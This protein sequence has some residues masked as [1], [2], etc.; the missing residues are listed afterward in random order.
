MA[1]I[2]GGV[3]MLLIAAGWSWAAEV[4]AVPPAALAAAASGK[5]AKG[6]PV[7]AP[8]VSPD[9][10]YLPAGKS[11]PFRPFIDTSMTPQKK[12]EAEA[13]K[14]VVVK[15]RSISPLQQAEIEKF[16]LVGIVGDDERRTAVVEDGT[17]KKFYP[18]FMGTT[19]GMN[20]G[21]IVS[22]LPD[23]VIIEERF[24]D[25]TKKTKKPQIRR[26]TLM[27]HKEDEGKP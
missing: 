3:L 25:E 17:T 10:S 13:K 19:I 27:L 23:S 4:K 9:Y 24:Q 2:T 1:A 21:R 20:E 18:L 22:I 26:I 14:K 6:A 5:E 16:R 12:K 15:A 7:I 8:D 11:D